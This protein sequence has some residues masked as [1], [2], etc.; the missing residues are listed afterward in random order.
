[1]SDLDRY[2]RVL[3]LEPGATLEEVN[4]AYKDLVFVWHPDRIPKDN[5]R[6]H[7]KALDKLKA[8]N[9]ARDQ[10]RSLKTKH[11]TTSHSPASQQQTPSQ[12][13]HQSAKK[14]SDLSGKDYS[15]ANLSNKDL[16][17]RNLSYANL[18]G[19]NLSDTF[20]HKVNL[21]GANLSE[22]NLFRANLL[23]AD[24]REANLRA[25]NLIGA[26][27]SGADLRGADLTGARIRSGERLL[28][29]LVG[30]NLAGAIMPDGTIYQ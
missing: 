28:V 29:K 19:A 21:R 6:L 16:S 5:L 10:L 11:P 7:Q 14:N 26:D 18:S 27:L 9:E 22:A 15:R 20:M 24:L 2:Y 8:I 13:P 30:T 25:T 3:E 17:G 23:L 4:Q 12:T 1:M